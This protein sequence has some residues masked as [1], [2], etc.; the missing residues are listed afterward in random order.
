MEK[1]FNSIFFDTPKIKGSSNNVSINVISTFNSFGIAQIKAF[2]EKKLITCL[3]LNKYLIESGEKVMKVLPNEFISNEEKFKLI[4]DDVIETI[5]N[6]YEYPMVIIVNYDAYST[7][8]QLTTLTILLK[9]KIENMNWYHLN[10]DLEAMLKLLYDVQ[11]NKIIYSLPDR[12]LKS[13]PIFYKK[14]NNYDNHSILITKEDIKYQLMN[15]KKWF[16]DEESLNSSITNL[17][18]E[19]NSDDNIYIHFHINSEYYIKY[20][21][22][23]RTD[24]DN[25]E[26]M[27]T[28]ININ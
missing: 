16:D 19:F 2:M 26:D 1:Y 20:I 10:F 14:R 21:D 7:L 28:K 5:K 11:Q 9:E 17:F 4:S 8:Y 3:E 24:L 18:N 13:L 27:L 6:I 23:N 22:I 25:F 15:F 12:F